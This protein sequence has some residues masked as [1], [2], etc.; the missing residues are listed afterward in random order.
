M[1]PKLRL[2]FKPNLISL[3]GGMGG[4]PITN[5]QSRATPLEPSAWKDMIAQAEVRGG[6]IESSSFLLIIVI[7]IQRI[8]IYLLPLSD[9]EC[10]RARCAQWLRVGRR[11]LLGRCPTSGGGLLRDSC[12]E[13][14]GGGSGSAQGRAG[15]NACHDVRAMFVH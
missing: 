7:T 14:R 3:A 4:L 8:T 9:K 5:P 12:G 2:K 1:F 11:P 6:L 15:G 13:G 10:G